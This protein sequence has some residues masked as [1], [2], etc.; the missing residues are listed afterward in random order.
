MI[1]EVH[2][3]NYDIKICLNNQFFYALRLIGWGGRP[4]TPDKIRHFRN[5]LILGRDAPGRGIMRVGNSHSINSSDYN[6]Y[7]A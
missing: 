7:R 2:I 6:G 4:R 1:S 5:N 3:N